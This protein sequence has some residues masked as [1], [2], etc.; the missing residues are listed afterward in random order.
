MIKGEVIVAPLADGKHWRVEKD[1]IYIDDKQSIEVRIPQGYIT[2]FAT[3]PRAFWWLL[4]PWGRYGTASII[5]DYLCDNKTIY[6]SGL[7]YKI[8]RK[9][10]DKIFNRAMRDTGVKKWRRIIIYTAV[11]AYAIFKKLICT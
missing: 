8:S 5:H 3:I 6:K 1:F 4:P 7:P 9:T 10:A 11:R 2:D